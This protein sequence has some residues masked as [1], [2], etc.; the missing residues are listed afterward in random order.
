MS[1]MASAFREAAR[2]RPDELVVVWLESPGGPIR[3]RVVG[4]HL[5]SRVTAPLRHLVGRQQPPA[6]RLDVWDETVAG[7]P[8]PLEFDP[9]A[10]PRDIIG[11]PVRVDDADPQRMWT[12][13]DGS[14]T[15]LDGAAGRMVAWRADG[16]RLSIEER[17]RPFPV[18]LQ[19]WLQ[20]R[21]VVTLHAAAVACEGRAALIVG[22][23][24]SGKSTAALACAEAGLAFLGDDQVP[25][26]RSNGA[27]VAHS[28]FASV[29]LDVIVERI[30]RLVAHDVQRSANGDG[31]G[32]VLLSQPGTMVV[33]S[34]RIAAII[35]ATVSPARESALER[36]SAKEALRA[37]VPST[38]LGV[39]TDRTAV[40]QGC[41]R[42]VLGSTTYR[43]R[44]GRDLDAVPRLVSQALADAS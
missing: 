36:T 9:P 18:A 40:L 25:V 32:L 34:A 42:T 15:E 27:A 31:K 10:F 3:L 43:L 6:L 33:P 5:A 26:S 39:L 29:R 28:L 2:R 35:V 16:S 20:S 23:S 4:R 11:T 17:G 7:V 13:A 22:D 41:V 1:A 19:T 44:S 21:G 30:G 8:C 37:L 38:M 24:G 12:A 14:L